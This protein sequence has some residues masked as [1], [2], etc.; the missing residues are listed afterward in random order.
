MLNAHTE[1]HQSRSSDSFR[2]KPLALRFLPCLLSFPM[3]DFRLWQ[4]TPE[5]TATVYRRGF[6]PHSLFTASAQTQHKRHSVCSY[7]ILWL[8]SNTLL[9]IISEFI[10]K[11]TA[12]NAAPL[13]AMSGS[14]ENSIFT[15][16]CSHK[17]RSF[18]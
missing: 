17:E 4:K 2:T 3:T 13:T 5:H 1:Q 11:F 6:A 14:V 9:Y 7:L 12:I 15:Q 10:D 16:H 8:Y 18:V